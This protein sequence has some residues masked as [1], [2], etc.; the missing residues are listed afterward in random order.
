MS[1]GL[2][3]SSGKVILSVLPD[4]SCLEL[5]GVLW[6]SRAA[7]RCLL[8]IWLIAQRPYQILHVLEIFEMASQSNFGTG[9][10]GAGKQEYERAERGRDATR[11]RKSIHLM[12]PREGGHRCA[13][14]IC[15]VG[16]SVLGGHAQP[17]RFDPNPVNVSNPYV[18]THT[19]IIEQRLLS[20]PGRS[21]HAT[22][23]SSDKKTSQFTDRTPEDDWRTPSTRPRLGAVNSD[24][25][26][27][28]WAFPPPRPS[29]S[30][31][32][33]LR[34][35]CAFPHSFLGQSQRRQRAQH[36]KRYTPWRQP[37]GR[38][39]E[40]NPMICHRK[41]RAQ[42]ALPAHRAKTA[43]ALVPSSISVSFELRSD[44]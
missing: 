17:I 10:A 14:C 23:T 24:V 2:T 8:H 36:R 9:A 32:K 25:S 3:A 35:T 27:H 26:R 5:L 40:R 38:S 44:R 19:D 4:W 34:M 39:R 37:L 33:A 18:Q 31:E 6:T 30:S 42:T 11:G 1:S 13:E 29:C 22:S 15:Q 16:G 20:C 43:S 28:L 7:P 12:K 41:R 21:G